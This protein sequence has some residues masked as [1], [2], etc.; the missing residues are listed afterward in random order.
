MGLTDD[1]NKDS[2]MYGTSP[3]DAL[4]EIKSQSGGRK[5]I[6]AYVTFNKD[7]SFA[8]ACRILED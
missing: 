2:V 5:L 1:A 8:D 3:E 6:K 7:L 4:A